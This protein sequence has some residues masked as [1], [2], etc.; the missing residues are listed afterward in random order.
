MSMLSTDELEKLSAAENL[1]ASPIPVQSVSSDE[2]MPCA[3]TRMQSEFEARVK[4]MGSRMARRLGMSRRRC[5]QSA[6]GMA[7][8]FLA[9]N[10]I[11][12]YDRKLERQLGLAPVN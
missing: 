7:T 2:F 4:D 10:D 1:F 11:Y 3:Q 9:I 5:F 12:G 6:A 8:A